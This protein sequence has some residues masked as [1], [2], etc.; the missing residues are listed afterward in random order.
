M[1]FGSVLAL[2]F[3]SKHSETYN[4]EKIKRR[5]I[6]VTSLSTVLAIFAFMVV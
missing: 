5:L 2:S 3:S 6:S 4:I 1:I